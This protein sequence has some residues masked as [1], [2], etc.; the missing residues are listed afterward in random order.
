MGEK[1]FHE[2]WWA[3][4]FWPQTALEAVAESAF[5]PSSDNA[6]GEAK[7]QKGQYADTPANRPSKCCNVIFMFPGRRKNQWVKRGRVWRRTY[8][9]E[10]EAACVCSI[11]VEALFVE[12]MFVE[13][14]VIYTR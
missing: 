5:P 3:Y 1:P 12:F 4:H 8:G 7:E 14:V 2:G 6:E 11:G 9:V 13:F 10:E